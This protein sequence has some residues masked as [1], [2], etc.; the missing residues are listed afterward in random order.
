MHDRD[1]SAKI[2]QERMKQFKEDMQRAEDFYDLKHPRPWTTDGQ[3]E[4]TN[5]FNLKMVSGLGACAFFMHLFAHASYFACKQQPNRACLRWH[6]V[7]SLHTGRQQC[8][9]NFWQAHKNRNA[10]VGWR[11][12]CRGQRTR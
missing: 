6:V 1:P 3:P 12:S 7:W 5:T 9:G 10:S 2:T 11:S 4:Q 8:L